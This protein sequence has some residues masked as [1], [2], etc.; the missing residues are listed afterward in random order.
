MKIVFLHKVLF[1]N[2]EEV[3][4]FVGWAVLVRVILNLINTLYTTIKHTMDQVWFCIDL[5]LH[6]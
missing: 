6:R 1:S 5:I 3:W 4:Q 2:L